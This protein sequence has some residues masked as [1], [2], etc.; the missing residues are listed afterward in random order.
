MSPTIVKVINVL[1]K[2]K[3]E[4]LTFLS[5]RAL[6]DLAWYVNRCERKRITGALIE[7]GSALGGSSL[8]MASAK[9][10]SR[11]LLIFDTFEGMPSPTEMD[12][13]DARKRYETIITGK[14]KGF[15]KQQYY[16]YQSNLFDQ[17]VYRFLK[18]GY[19]I[20]RNNI[21]LIKGLVE[22]TLNITEPVA[23]AHID[24]DWYS[25]VKVSIERI[26]PFLSKGG[27]FIVDDYY[28]W[29]G[30]KKAVDE[31]LSS[32]PEFKLEYHSRIH[33]VKKW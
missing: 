24:C 28:H 1:I 10:T 30:A 11:S 7:I 14:A 6:A 33:L 12:G 25:P 29:S 20:Q 31:F 18:F 15:G 17:I 16:G 21:Y 32:H 26:A 27:R 8:V 13:D 2:V 3:I 23:L 4:H 22:E 19:P 5:V 9:N